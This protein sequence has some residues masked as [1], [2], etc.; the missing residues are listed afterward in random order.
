[1]PQNR[2]DSFG[3]RTEIDTALGRRTIYLLDVLK[4]FGDIGTLPYCITVLLEAC[5]RHCDGRAVTADHVQAV[6]SYE[7]RNVAVVEV[8]FRPS[9][10]ILQDFTGVPALVD[11][12]AMRDAIVEMT[13]DETSAR[14]V[15][16]LVPCDLIVD[17]SVQVDAFATHAALSVNSR[18]EFERNQQRYRFLKWGQGAFQNFR[19]VPPATGIVHQINLEHL[20]KVVWDAGPIDSVLHPD[21]LLGTDSHTTMIN[22]LGVLGW[23]RRRHRSRSSHARPAGVHALAGSGRRPCDRHTA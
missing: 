23:G 6:A 4:R 17:H 5:L 8:P 1:M 14:R 20:A 16:P 3:A 21:S 18:K 12:A 10:I 11:L 19:V 9:R 22:G 15:N 2:L 13:G 7:A